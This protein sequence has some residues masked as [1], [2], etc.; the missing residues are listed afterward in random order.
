MSAGRRATKTFP[1]RR[2][3]EP[4]DVVLTFKINFGDQPRDA[5]TL[6]DGQRVPFAGSIFDNRDRLARGLV[7]LLM[8]ASAMQ[9]RVWAAMLALRRRAT[10]GK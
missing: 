6:V 8:K 3:K 10:F 7:R 9:P 5:L 4:L 2:S 1:G